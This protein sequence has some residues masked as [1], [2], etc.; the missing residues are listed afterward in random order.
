MRRN[1]A[2]KGKGGEN[3]Q[4]AVEA[5]MLEKQPPLRLFF[6]Q[7][8]LSAPFTISAYVPLKLQLQ[9]LP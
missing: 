8:R 5:E 6:F 9:K 3:R 7:K 1:E 2:L 4:K